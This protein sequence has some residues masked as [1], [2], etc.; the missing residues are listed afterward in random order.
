MN[1]YKLVFIFSVVLFPSCRYIPNRN[2]QENSTNVTTVSGDTSNSKITFYNVNGKG[3][4]LGKNIQLLDDNFNAIK[5]ISYLNEQFVEITQVS[6]QYHK[7]NPTDDYCDEFKYV[8]IKTKDV[9]GYIDGR[10]LYDNAQMKKLGFYYNS[11][12]REVVNIEKN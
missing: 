5:D 3:I 12:G 1:V 2:S 9:I 7:V 10:N 6:H 11:V 8:R 4:L